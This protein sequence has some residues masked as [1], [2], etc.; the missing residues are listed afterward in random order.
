MRTFQSRALALSRCSLEVVLPGAHV[1]LPSKEVYES[2][3][4]RWRRG[5]GRG[6]QG[7]GPDLP[8]RRGPTA[9]SGSTTTCSCGSPRTCFPPPP[10]PLAPLASQMPQASGTTASRCA[11]LPSS[12]VGGV[13]WWG[14]AAGAA[15]P[16]LLPTRLLA[17]PPDSDSDDEDTHFSVGASGTPQRLAPE[18]QSPHSQS[19]F[20]TLVTVL[21]GRITAHCETKVSTA[22]GR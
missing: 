14:P 15:L 1:F 13:P 20:S 6:W 21:K 8:H 3:Y 12:W 9:P 19:T 4:N 5:Q 22:Q 10:L 7:A 16:G 11:S 18:S 2:L 17:L